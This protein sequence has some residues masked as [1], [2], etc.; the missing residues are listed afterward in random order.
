MLAS[1]FGSES[2]SNYDR[3]LL[4]RFDVRGEPMQRLRLSL[5]YKW[6]LAAITAVTFGMNCQCLPAVELFSADTVSSDQITENLTAIEEGRWTASEAFR[7]GEELENLNQRVEAIRLYE[8]ALKKF[9]ED[10]NLKYALRRTRVHFSVDRR[11]SDRSFQE[12]LLRQ[13]RAEALDLMEDVLTRVQLEYV[14]KISATKLIAH[15]TESLYMALGNDRFLD[16]HV[17][18]AFRPAAEKLR[19]QLTSNYWNRRVASRLEARMVVTEVCELAKR[20]VGIPDTAVVMEY[21]F[22]SC[23]ALDDYSHFLT[24]D[25][26]NDLFGSIQGEFV[27]I[28][29]EMEGEKGKGMHLVNVLLDSPAEEGGLRPGDFI[30]EIDGQECRDL[31]TDE[32]AGLLRG[33]RGSQVDIAYET[34]AGKINRS[35]LTRRS[36]VVRSVTSSLILDQD[37]GIG[38]IRMTGFQNS[39]EEEM[40]AALRDLERRGMKSLIWDLRDNPGGLL[41]TAANVIDRFIDRGVLVSTEGRSFDQTQTFRA[42]S[43]NTRSVPLVLLVN[44]NSASASEIVAGA[45]NDHQRGTIVGRRTYGKWSVQSIIHLP[46]GTGLKLTTAKFYSPEHQNYA[47]TGIAPHVAVENTHRTAFRA[48]TSDE[49]SVDPDVARALEV[50]ERRF[51]RNN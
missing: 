16:A 22:G 3:S 14:T 5:A 42:N 33:Q 50:L 48:R 51:T 24:P 41:D 35:V 30:V 36:V 45:I 6:V 11:Y 13:G 17:K 10:G 28:G 32:A 44:E 8:A 23:N 25:R 43:Y 15:G 21:L 18:S 12:K 40:D 38:Y 49:I 29:I 19:K 47:G 26:Y 2:Q 4:I 20:Q 27:G 31:T 46:G 37:R 34:T 9:P 1:P 39:T 7:F